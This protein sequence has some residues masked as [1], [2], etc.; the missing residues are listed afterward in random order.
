[1]AYIF[2][3]QVLLLIFGCHKEFWSA[4]GHVVSGTK[5]VLDGGCCDLVVMIRARRGLLDGVGRRTIIGGGFSSGAGRLA[6][7]VSTVEMEEVLE[8][9]WFPY[10]FP[11]AVS[12]P[13]VLHSVSCCLPIAL[14]PCPIRFS[15]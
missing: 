14:C 15:L 5:I 11:S 10:I 6:P 3:G 8:F 12:F 1:M 2:Q 9:L 7:S 13:S 4:A